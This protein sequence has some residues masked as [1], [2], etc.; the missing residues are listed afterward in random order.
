MNDII[1]LIFN[2]NHN[3]RSEFEQILLESLTLKKADLAAIL[4]F[5]TLWDKLKLKR[6][7]DKSILEFRDFTALLYFSMM[8]GLTP[9]KILRDILSPLAAF[10]RS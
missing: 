6:I 7:E 2:K 4:L 1:L 10:L 3:C 9:Y 5:I 8:L